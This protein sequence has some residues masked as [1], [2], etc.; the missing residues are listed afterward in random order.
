MKLMVYAV[1]D[2]KVGAFTPPLF[3]RAAG[4]A[5][6]SFQEA[7]NHREGNFFKY[8]MDYELCSLG[9]WDDNSGIFESVPPVRV[10]GAHEVIM[11]DVIPPRAPNGDASRPS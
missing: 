6:R 9:H 2:K 5:L 1:F 11:D 4:E 8:A 7:C 3:V 10:I